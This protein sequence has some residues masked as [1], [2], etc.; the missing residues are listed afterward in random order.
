MAA[1]PL[2][3]T[4]VLFFKKEKYPAVGMMTKSQRCLSLLKLLRYKTN[5]S[6]H[7]LV[8]FDHVDNFSIT[9]YLNFFFYLLELKFLCGR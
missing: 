8:V 2:N 4:D 7:D 1:V 3:P 6:V 5:K 9:A